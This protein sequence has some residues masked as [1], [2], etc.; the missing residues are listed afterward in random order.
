MSH[1]LH[2]IDLN[3]SSV[4]MGSEGIAATFLCVDIHLVTYIE[5]HDLKLT[6]KVVQL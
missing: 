1:P 5:Q 2:T 6:N 3:R 4:Q